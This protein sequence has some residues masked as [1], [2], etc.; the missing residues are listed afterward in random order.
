MLY[1]NSTGRPIG[2]TIIGGAPVSGGSS[3]S[4]YVNGVPVSYYTTNAFN[5]PLSAIVPPRATYMAMGANWNFAFGAPYGWKE[6]R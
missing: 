6:L 2:V 3:A 4:L 1:T 5:G